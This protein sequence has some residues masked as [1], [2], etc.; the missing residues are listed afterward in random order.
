MKQLLVLAL[1][2]LLL[3]PVGA[4][5]Q[6]P[7]FSGPQPGERITPFKTFAPVG[8]DAGKEV[9]YVARYQGAPSVLVFVHG[10][11]RSMAPLLTTI[12]QY[13]FEKGDRLKAV[14]VFLTAD[15]VGLE[16]RLPL[17]GRSLQMRSPLAI[18]LDG[19]EGP[20]NYGLNKKCLL[21]IVGAKENRVVANFALVQPG[22][23]DAPKVLA[24]LAQLAGDPQPPGAEELRARRGENR[25]PRPQP[26]RPA[27]GK[28]LPGAAPTDP[29]LISHLRAFI[30]KTNGPADVDRVLR[31]VERYVQGKPELTRQAIDG[32]TRV[33]YLKYG[34]DYAQKTGAE[35]L[36]RL[37]KRD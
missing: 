25:K 31:E 34:T 1:F 19:A 37:K 8:P 13:A 14:F 17:V 33:L 3:A 10:L 4:Q 7:V 28:E 24:A 29:E 9:D 27:P 2:T 18:S 26:N 30:Q 36:E 15:R 6:E 20:G 11:E 32:W 21:T 5:A 22:I 23:A 12:D 35:W 16:Q